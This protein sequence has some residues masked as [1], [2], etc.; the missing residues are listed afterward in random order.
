MYHISIKGTGSYAPAKV[1]TNHDLAKIMDT[2]DEWIRT[3]TGIQRRH[4][5]ETENTSKLAYEAGKKALEMAGV[6]GEDLD[7]IVCAT[8]TPDAFTPATACIIQDFLGA[9]HAAAFDINAACTGLIYG[10]VT[11]AQFLQNGMY[12][13]ALVIGAE[14]LSKLL[15][16][17]DR[18][19]C[20]LFGDGAGAVY[21]ERTTELQGVI[22]ETALTADGSK[23][24][25][26]EC[27]AMPLKTISDHNNKTNELSDNGIVRDENQR[28]HKSTVS[29]IAMQGG[30]VFKF[31]VKAMV[32]SVQD[33]LEKNGIK[34]EEIDWIV[35]HQANV[36]IIESAAKLLKTEE[37][38]F[39]V[40]L[41]AYG[42]TSSA[43][44]GLA[45]DE[46]NRSGRLK[47]GQKLILVGFGGGMTS[48]AVLIEW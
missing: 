15:D 45:L 40:N 7:L 48:G 3:R 34:I 43:S 42:N 16:W 8:L 19:T 2:S 39:F 1:V 33:V 9:R 22:L 36:R 26:L 5:S 27:Y 21:L 30:E 44:I 18:N 6:N 38:R 47:R 17:S 29:T 14:T 37:S 13:N 35:P 31:A 32:G 23:H 4:I 11:A 10:M 41:S 20:V 12:G 24:E 46:L 25:L 28:I